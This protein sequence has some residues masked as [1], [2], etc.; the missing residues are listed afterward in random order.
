[1]NMNINMLKKISIHVLLISLFI[2]PVFVFADN[3]SIPIRITNPF[4]GGDSLS[5][6]ITTVLNNVV[7]PIAAVVVVIWIVWAGFT[8][9]MAQ[10]NPKKIEEAQQRLL[11]S[12]IGAGI[13]LGAA[14]I[15]AVVQNTVGALIAP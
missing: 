12:L 7:M 3:T 1:M 14:G 6:L 8:F 13:L 10:G 11:W 4:K 9:V 2:L 5:E 15:S